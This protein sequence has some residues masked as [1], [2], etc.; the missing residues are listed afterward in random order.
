ML[1]EVWMSQNT[2]YCPDT[3]L[4]GGNIF[5]RVCHSVHGVGCIP[6]CIW[7]GGLCIPAC[8]RVVVWTRVYP[9]MH[10]GRRQGVDRGV[11]TRT[12]PPPHSLPVH[13]SSLSGTVTEASG[14]HPI[15]M[16]ILIYWSQI[17]WVI[18]KTYDYCFNVV[19]Y[20]HV[21]DSAT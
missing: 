2:R 1:S 12:V 18:P 17:S 6:A 14:M 16:H 11:Y 10:L 3:K 15:G 19:W 20:L 13:M 9:S 8:T 4:R 7:P 5:T 21:V